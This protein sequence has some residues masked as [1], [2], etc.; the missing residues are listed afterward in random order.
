MNLSD[1][2]DSNIELDAEISLGDVTLPLPAGPGVC[3]FTNADDQPI[4]LLPSA[5]LR[6]LVRRR[7][8]PT[9]DAATRRTDL[10]AITRRVW[11]R[12]TFSAFETQLAFWRLARQLFPDT[13]RELMG[14]SYVWF[15]HV[16]PA[17]S[18]AHFTVTNKLTAP[19]R[20]WGP[21]PDKKAPQHIAE[22]LL[23]IFA[24]CRQPHPGRDRC[25]PASCVYAQMGR[26]A[27]IEN[28]RFNESRH[29]QLIN[30]AINF[31]GRPLEENLQIIHQQMTTAAR[32]QAYEQAQHLKAQILAAEKLK[33]H[34]YLYINDLCIFC[35]LAF[36]PGPKLPHPDH[37]AGRPRPTIA[38]FIIRPGHIEPLKM[39]H[40]EH[41]AAA[42]AAILDR[43]RATLAAPFAVDQPSPQVELLG[44][45]SRFLYGTEPREG[46]YLPYE[47]SLTATEV[48]ERVVDNFTKQ[49][50]TVAGD[51]ADGKSTNL[52]EVQDAEAND[53]VADRLDV[54]RV[55]GDG[56]QPGH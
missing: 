9:E 20:Y 12:R 7:L 56:L 4:L 11:F 30:E 19:G 33:K 38:P 10:A 44:W 48:A 54:D 25:D 49:P 31:L 28:G 8:T 26:C 15:L 22:T 18:L 6:S 34:N 2:F 35:V 43:C 45:I 51:Y 29:R 42:Y 36:Q 17:E 1:I 40:V 14:R 32:D 55:A 5:R 50:P 21:Y 23:D 41:S 39:F 27:A 24:L 52:T 37:P 53:E 3:L 16:N 46:V 47:A 13:W